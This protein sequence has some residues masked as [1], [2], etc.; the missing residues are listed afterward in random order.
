MGEVVEAMVSQ[1]QLA[2]TT[3]GRKRKVSIHTPTRVLN[4]VTR[5]LTTQIRG[6]IFLKI[7]NT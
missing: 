4:R 3:T 7:G 5:G 2:M 1:R 6:K